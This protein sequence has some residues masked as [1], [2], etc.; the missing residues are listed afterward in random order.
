MEG[1]DMYAVLF[2]IERISVDTPREFSRYYELEVADRSLRDII[3]EKYKWAWKCT[4]NTAE[5]ITALRAAYKELPRDTN[6]EDYVRDLA[7]KYGGIAG[8]SEISYQRDQRDKARRMI[9]EEGFEM[10]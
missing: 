3:K 9:Q 7:Q 10:Y 8:Y 2:D 4:Q 5:D 1:W 6:I